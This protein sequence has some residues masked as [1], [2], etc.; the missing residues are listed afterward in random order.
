MMRTNLL[1]DAATA[2]MGRP[3]NGAGPARLGTGFG[4]DFA[5]VE[6]PAAAVS[7]DGAGSYY[8]GGAAGAWFWTRIRR[9]T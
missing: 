6:D 2:T 9:P 5:I 8:W 1:S 7:L 4:L 3:N